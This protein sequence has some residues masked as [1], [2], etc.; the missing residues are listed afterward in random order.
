MVTGIN[1]FC[2]CFVYLGT[3]GQSSGDLRLYPTSYYSSGGRLEMY[4]SYS[5]GWTPF[6]IAGFDMHDADL[7]CKQLGYSYASRYA[8]VATL[9]YVSSYLMSRLL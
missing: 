2:F 9:G 4:Y 3:L 1:C 7:A 6:T 8:K 5:Y